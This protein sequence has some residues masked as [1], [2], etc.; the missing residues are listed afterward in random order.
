MVCTAAGQ[1]I[2]HMCPHHFLAS[3]VEP[4][5]S[6]EFGFGFH[7]IINSHLSHKSVSSY[8]FPSGLVLIFSGVA[9]PWSL[10]QHTVRVNI[11]AWRMFLFVE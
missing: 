1:S 7:W 2:G 5:C 4:G 11:L 8:D 6:C 9:P 10:D 3:S